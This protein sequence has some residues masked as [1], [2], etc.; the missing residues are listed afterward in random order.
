[1]AS[2]GAGGAVAA[3]ILPILAGL[4]HP[5]GR[6]GER[7]GERWPRRGLRVCEGAV[8]SRRPAHVVDA[9]VRGVCGDT[10]RSGREEDSSHSF[11]PAAPVWG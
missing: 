5:A 8:E 3:L 11:D 10:S 9:S 6:D 4:A 1:M 7:C 2:I